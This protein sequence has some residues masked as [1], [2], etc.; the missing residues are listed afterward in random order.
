MA[1]NY[2]RVWRRQFEVIDWLETVKPYHSFTTDPN[3]ALRIGQAAGRKI[4]WDSNK[5]AGP[6]TAYGLIQA[7]APVP[8][9]APDGATATRAPLRVITQVE[10]AASDEL[11][12]AMKA[13]AK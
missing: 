3:R 13:G 11:V 4:V 5:E 7:P 8:A 2:V 10:L 6:A 12:R 9:A 1:R